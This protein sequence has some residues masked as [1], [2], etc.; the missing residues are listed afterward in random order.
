LLNVAY[1]TPKDIFVYMNCTF[2]LLRAEIF[3]LLNEVNFAC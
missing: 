2:Q 1:L 3:F